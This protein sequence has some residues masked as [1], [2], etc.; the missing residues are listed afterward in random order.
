[1]NIFIMALEP[2][3]TRYTGQWFNGLPKLLRETADHSGKQVCIY[4]IAGEQTSTVTTSGAFLDF[5]ATN[6]WKN[7]QINKLV[8]FFQSG[9]VKA[10]DKIL[11]TD[12]WHTGL[13]QVRYMSELMGIPVEIH[14]MWHAGSYDPQ[15][16]LGRL[17]KDKS[18]TYNTE[19]A[20]FHASTYNYFATQFHW[21]LF[22]DTIFEDLQS[23]D[24]V[25]VA[26]K[27]VISGQP[28]AALIAA[29]EPFAGM[30]KE[31]MVLFPHRVAPEKQPEIFRDLARSMPDVKF[32]ICQDHK[33]SKDEYHT[34]LGKS[35]IVFSANLQETLGISAMEGVLVGA[36]PLMPDRL[37][38]SEMYRPE[39]L[40]LSEWTEDWKAYSDNKD[41]LIR[42]IRYMLDHY[43]SY[44]DSIDIQK[45]RLL[46]RYLTCDPMLDRL[47]K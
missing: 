7:T 40:Y 27:R 29:L 20:L 10:G 11:F 13:L 34:L 2:L 38:Y 26:K 25:D 33:L 9:L 19:R 31:N 36:L 3:D 14:S 35:K 18:W 23:W 41:R 47:L 4:N 46:G 45:Q 43:D 28:H 24:L 42:A 1:M 32:V 6:V 5:F 15:D 8:E 30:E 39:F 21:Q 12:A 37:S 17:I 16:F 22:R 44:Q